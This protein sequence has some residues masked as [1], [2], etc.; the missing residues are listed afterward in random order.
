MLYYLF[1]GVCDLLCVGCFYDV[2]FGVFGYCCVFDGLELIGYGLVDDQDLLLFNLMFDVVLFGDGF[3]FVFVVLLE[4][5]VQVFYVV[6]M[7]V[8]GI[9]NGGFGL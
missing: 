2:M 7:V 5:V 9:D 3:Y 6:G 8:G 4:L 1:F